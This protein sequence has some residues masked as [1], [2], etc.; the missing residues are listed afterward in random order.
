M[1]LAKK[2]KWLGL[3]NHNMNLLNIL[4]VSRKSI[5]FPCGN[6]YIYIF[7]FPENKLSLA[8]IDRGGIVT[9]YWWL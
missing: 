7:F 4:A 1:Y 5:Y 6:L 8:V 3:G 9:K 2:K